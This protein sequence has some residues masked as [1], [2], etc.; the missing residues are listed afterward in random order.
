M[1][2][3]LGAP[4][5]SLQ[6]GFLH[7]ASGSQ[8]QVYSKNGF[9]HHKLLEH[10]FVADY[11]I[12]YS[13]GHGIVG[14]SY[15]IELGGRLFQSPASY[16]IG[17]S[18][19]DVSP[20]YEHDHILDFSRS[21]TQDCLFCHA[22]AIKKTADRVALEPIS[23]ER[24][25]GPSEQHRANPVAGTIVNP[26]KLPVRERDSVCEQCHLEGVTTV[27]NPGKYWTDFR[28]GLPL[29][30]V[31]IHYV[32]RTTGGDQDSI[33]AVSH[34]EQLALSK[35]LRGSA[36]K[37]W[38]GTCHDPHGDSVADRKQQVRQICESCHPPAELASTHK[39]ADQDCVTCHMPRR[40]AADIAHASVTDHRIIRWP[41]SLQDIS[42]NPVLGPWHDPPP[43]FAIRNLGL[44]YFNVA[45]EKRSAPYFE[46]SYRLLS[47]LPSSQKDDA[48]SA[49]EGYML[50]A[51]GQALEAVLF[52]KRAAQ[53][54]PG[55]A[56]RWLDLGIAQN[57]SGTVA[58]AINS[59]RQSIALEPYDYR[60]Y[61]A[62]ANV[63]RK[64]GRPQQSQAVIDEFLRL[65]PQSLIMRIEPAEPVR[66]R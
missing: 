13:V 45:R 57:N 54:D 7:I 2:Q 15:L 38:C 5:Q 56:E 59:L 51:S 25:H 36:G 11:P 42:D 64:T 65:M 17:R 63:Y 26:A 19:W 55:R 34:A 32:Y 14:H 39:P 47:S 30:Q 50:L 23:C 60:P 35:S 44:A 43:E 6:G 46:R 21:I 37:L 53:Q 40:K 12:A 29:E 33:L 4:D 3:S 31:E 49:A 41:A 24:C 28:P 27:L 10:G 20:G 22:G 58:D 9:M 8:I 61:K 16:Y 62:L 1:G 18:E 48:V 52:F 66:V